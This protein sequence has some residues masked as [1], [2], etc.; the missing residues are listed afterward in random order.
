MLQ[1]HEHIITLPEQALLA[2]DILERSGC[3]AWCV[4][5]FVRDTLMD[6]PTSDIDIA[7]AAPWD[8]TKDLFETA[9][10]FVAETGIK[11]GTVT[12]I[13]DSTPLEITTYRTD[14]LY[15]DHRHPE[16]VTFVQSIEE[17]LARRDFTMNAIAYHPQRGLFDPFDGIEDIQQHIIRAV[18][19]PQKRF[20]EDA[21]RILRGMRFVSQLG[22]TLEDKTYKGMCDQAHLL[23]TIA[24]ERVAVELEGFLLGDNIHDALMSYIDVI[25]IVVPEAL[26]MKDFDQKTPYH[27]YDVLEHT[28]YVLQNTPSYPLVRWAAFFHDIG[29][30]ATFF[31]DDNGVGHFYGH[32]KISVK[33]ARAVM[34][35]LRMPN[36][37][38]NDVLTLVKVH[39]DVVAATPKSIKRMIRKMGGNVDLFY[40]LCDLKKGDAAGQAPKCANRIKLADELAQVAR[41]LVASQEVFSLKD[42][43]IKGGDLIAHGT[44][45][46]P[47]VGKLLEQ[48]LD[49]VIDEQVINEKE[50]LLAYLF[51]P[52]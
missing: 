6:R 37:L 1:P 17:D 13:I 39:D 19:E 46:G 41:D 34:K 36:K 51:D 35:R 43:A 52:W 16:T 14:G 44:P 12:V 33:V 8:Q 20:S 31:T 27:I 15:L 26:P 11:H 18:G 38:I 23:T 30:P 2:L 9:G 50:A 29:K 48:A 24:S 21:L 32:A 3:E 10:Y 42:L 45:P 4:G 49:A 47:E 28:A 22:F 7:T 25:G 5:G 40:A